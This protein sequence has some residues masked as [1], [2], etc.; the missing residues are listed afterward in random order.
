MRGVYLLAVGAAASSI[1]SDG[2]RNA[3]DLAAN[4][5]RRVVNLLTAMQK[6]VEADGKRETELYDKYMCYC[7]TA[8]TTLGAAIDAADTKLPQ[9]ASS[10]KE[11]EASKVQLEAELKDH[12]ASRAEAK[13]AMAKAAALREKEATVYAKD[14]GDMKTNIGAMDKAITAIENG[15]S[16]AFLQSTSAQAVQ[17]IAIDSADMTTYDRRMVLAFL[18]GKSEDGYTPASGQITGILKEMKSTMEAELKD[19]TD[20]ETAAKTT[21]DELMAAKTKE[22]EANTQAIEEKTVR[23]GNLGVEI[24]GMKNDLDD[25]QQQLMEDQDFLANMDKNCATKEKEWEGICAARSQE[26]IA[27][28]ETIKILNDDDALELF[29]KTL[30]AADASLVQVVGSNVHV[31]HKA[32]GMVQQMRK[33]VGKDRHT[34]LDLIALAL[35]GKKVNFDKVMGLI[36]GLVSTLQNEQLDDEHKKEYCEKQFDFTDDKKKGLEQNLADLET[37]IE[38]TTEKIATLTDELKALADGIVALDKEVKE[39]TETRKEEHEEYTELMAGNNAAKDLLGVAKNRMNKFYNPKLYKAPP[40][41][42]L[43]EEERISENMGVSFVQIRSHSNKADPGPPPEAPG[44]FEKK[45]EESNGVLAMIDMIVADLDKETQEAEIMETDAQK[46]YETFMKDAAMKRVTDS[47]A[48]TDKEGAKADGEAAL[49]AAKEEKL[50]K[51]KELMATEKY[52]ASLHLECD[53]LIKNFDLRKEARAVE[54]DSLKKAKA[55]LAGADFSL[56]QKGSQ[57]R[58]RGSA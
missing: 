9:V 49:E 19:I 54:I 47:K 2:Q 21:F 30:P 5:I 12:Q 57:A 56:M 6:K 13:S 52:I 37:T 17:R 11:G 14:S 7:K 8:G 40:K 38:D 16:G 44:S 42:E 35:T 23:V 1:D 28:S 3:A 55:V 41:R 27:I 51:V 43:T 39:S 18:T 50:S 32:L 25:T 33:D 20:T 36:D 31:A 48:I 4:P 53:W 26:L 29:K 34:A 46:E 45:T 10:I 58:L 24:E 15:M 22:V